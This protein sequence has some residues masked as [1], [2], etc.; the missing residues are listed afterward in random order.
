LP[1]VFDFLERGRRY[2]LL[3]MPQEAINDFSR[4]IALDPQ[5]P[6]GYY[7]HAMMLKATGKSWR[8]LDNFN[9]CIELDPQSPKTMW[10]EGHCFGPPDY[11]MTRW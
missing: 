10:G 3:D 1:G 9:R 7:E 2:V 5:N 8:S 4:V 6:D 11:S